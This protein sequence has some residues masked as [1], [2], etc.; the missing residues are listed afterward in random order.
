MNKFKKQ[1]K[2]SWKSFT[3]WFNT[4]GLM[5][6]TIATTEPLLLEYMTEHGLLLVVITGNMVLRF[7]TTQA[8]EEKQ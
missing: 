4:V 3:L 7:K 6:L 5:L 2:N 1:I 8:L